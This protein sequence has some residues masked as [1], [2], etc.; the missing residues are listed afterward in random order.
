M[1]VSV[2]DRGEVSQVLEIEVPAEEVTA[3]Y[4]RAF[5]KAAKE[6]NLPGFRKGKV[7]RDVLE[8]RMGPS[9]EQEVLNEILSKAT[10]EAVRQESI[11]AVGR[12]R[13][14]WIDFKGVAAKSPLLFKARIEVK[15][16]FTLASKL[17]G[18]ELKAVSAAVSDAE[19]EAK[20]EELRQREAKPGASLSRAS[21]KGDLL[22]IDFEGRIGGQVFPGG[23]AKG[24][25]LTLGSNSLIPGFEE[26]LEGVSK[27]AVKAVHV[28][29]PAEYPAQDVA[30]KEAEFTVTVHDIQERVLPA[31]DD[32][33]ATSLGPDVKD[34]ADLRSKLRQALTAQKERNRKAQLQEAAAGLLLDKHSFAVPESLIEGEQQAMLQQEQNS[35]RQRGVEVSGGEQGLASL[36]Q[37]MR[38]AAERRARLALILDKVAKEKAL[39]VS[40]EDFVA[41][42]GKLAPSLGAT[43]EQ[44]ITWARQTGREEGFRGR[45]REE[46]A[47]N[48]IVEN[49]KL[50]DSN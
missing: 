25:G 48:W 11:A 23:T 42:M 1:K 2:V 30:G 22:S 45:L 33:F 34:L 24:Y 28:T 43:P 18:L 37:A 7:P 29:F 21:Q 44:A 19:V 12:P 14:E 13:V 5:A 40:E 32:A 41:E 39:E 50:S 8:K 35:M 10:F 26:Q 36:A 49:A 9:V 31:A 17:D 20:V 4:E 46:K 27:G 16:E 47:L 3:E 6:A 15:P 38:P